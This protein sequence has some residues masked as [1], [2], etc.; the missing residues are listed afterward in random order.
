MNTKTACFTGPRPK[1]ILGYAYGY[2]P[3]SYESFIIQLKDYLKH[4]YDTQN[5]TTFI[6]GGA[7]GFDQIA[8]QAVELLKSERTG[9]KNVVYVPFKGQERQW[10]ETGMFSQAEYH[11]MIEKADTVRYLRQ[12]LYDSS[13][14][15]QALF[16]RNHKMLQASDFVIALY[17]DDTWLQA[18]G[19]TAECMRYAKKSKKP[20][21]QIVYSVTNNEIVMNGVKTWQ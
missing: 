17:K 4:L 20:I 9:I 16:D 3:K 19:G 8:F 7:Q 5:V 1:N 14:I 2:N 10:K 13:A 11:A 6:T 18:K 15:I 12:E 21:E